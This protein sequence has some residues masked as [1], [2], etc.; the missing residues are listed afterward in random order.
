MHL[1]SRTSVHNVVHN[2]GNSSIINEKKDRHTLKPRTYSRVLTT[3]L[4]RSN[5]LASQLKNPRFKKTACPV[6]S[7]AS[8]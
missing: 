5:V 3:A 2:M 7:L 1:A 6:C 4:Q 8:A